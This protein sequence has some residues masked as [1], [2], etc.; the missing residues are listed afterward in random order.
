MADKFNNHK[1][2]QAKNRILSTYLQKVHKR[3]SNTQ[4]DKDTEASI[5]FNIEYK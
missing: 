4:K 1:R 5:F 3:A 2:F